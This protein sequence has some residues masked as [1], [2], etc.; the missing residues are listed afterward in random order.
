MLEKAQSPT[1]QRLRPAARR[2]ARIHRAG[3]ARGRDRAHQGRR[4][5]ARNGHAGRDREPRPAGAAGD[6]VRGRAGLSQGHAA[7]LRRHQFIEAA[8]DHAR[9]AGPRQS[10]RRGAR[11]SRPHE[12]PP[13]DPAQDRGERPGVRERR[14]RR[15]G[16][17]AEVPG[18]VPA[19]ARRRPLHRHRRSRDHARPGGELGQR[20]DLPRHGAGQEPRV[21]LDLA[22]Q[23]RPADP[24]EVFP[25]RESPV[26]C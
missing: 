26:R 10:A 7:A 3:R 6:P 24:R 11:L 12:D 17:R 1:L 25:R 4:L 15:Q 9:L 21:A 19:R 13:A 8:R 14:P 22:R 18:A 2:S 20:R 5:E 23:A 16:R